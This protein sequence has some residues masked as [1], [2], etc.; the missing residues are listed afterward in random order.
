MHELA[1]ILPVELIDEIL[2]IATPSNPQLARIC[3]ISKQFLWPARKLLYDSLELFFVPYRGSLVGRRT[4]TF[5]ILRTLENNVGI[6]QLPST[7]SFNYSDSQYR[8]YMTSGPEQRENTIIK[9]ALSLLP[10]ANCIIL[11]HHFSAPASIISSQVAVVK[12]VTSLTLACLSSHDF[13]LFS[14]LRTI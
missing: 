11:D 10:K 4:Q 1:P 8:N 14:Q 2:R 13:K 7:V 6:R 5:R 12:T 3:L 9:T